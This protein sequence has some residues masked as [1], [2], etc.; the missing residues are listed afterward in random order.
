MASSGGGKKDA[1]SARGELDVISPPT[2]PRANASGGAQ[3]A[4]LSPGVHPLDIRPKRRD[5]LLYVPAKAH[6]GALVVYLHGAGGSEE[7]GI[8]RMGPLAD[9]LG[10]LLL[11]PAS[12]DRTWDAIQG[13][14]GKDVQAIGQALSRAMDL[15]PTIDAKRVVVA[16]FSDGASYALGLGMRNPGLFS[17]IVAFSPGFIPGGGVRAGAGKAPRVF[18]S[19]GTDDAILP[20]DSCSRQMVPLIKRDGYA[21]TYRE[22][23]GPHT[24]P[25]EIAEE[26][27]RWATTA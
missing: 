6:N 11:S 24:V 2:P 1:K 10:F 15:A 18:V 9:D 12:E 8:K 25:K 14:Y 27:L 26:A 7:Q 19:H 23:T 22:F 17:S 3:T 5:A 4:P 21:V 13:D 20:I 16:G